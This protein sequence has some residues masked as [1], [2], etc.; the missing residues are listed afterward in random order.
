MSDMPNKAA[1]DRALDAARRN[2]SAEDAAKVERLSK[3]PRSLQQLTASLNAKDWAVVNRVLNDPEMLRKILGS[4][5]GKNALHE[6]L[7]N[8]P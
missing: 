5:R 2:L 8:I 7:R 4:T 3:D 6:F 1:L